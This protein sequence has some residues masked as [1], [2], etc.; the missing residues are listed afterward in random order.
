MSQKDAGHM[1]AIDHEVG[2]A[3][4]AVCSGLYATDLVL[5]NMLEFRGP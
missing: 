2:Q 3:S 5:G 4:S 1:P